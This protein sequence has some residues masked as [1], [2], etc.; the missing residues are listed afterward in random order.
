MLA[1]LSAAAGFNLFHTQPYLSLRIESSDDLET[2]VLLL[3][4][5]LDRRG[6][7]PA[8]SAGPL[9]RHAE[10]AATSPRCTDSAHSSP[11]GEDPDYV[12]LATADELTQ[13]L[14]LVDCRYET[15]TPDAKVLPVIDR[16]GDV[17]WG[18]TPWDA[19]MWGM[20]S[21]GAA[22]DVWAHGER[23]GRFVLQAPLGVSLPKEQ[24]ARAAALV[25]L[26]GAALP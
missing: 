1:A 18:P 23:R 14:G 10:H 6:G 8:R 4:V 26:A 5:G 11:P 20:P 19:R 25:D 13:L 24:L 15:P 7:G 9:R 21:E 17:R 16:H 12:L 2:T 3:V 22:I